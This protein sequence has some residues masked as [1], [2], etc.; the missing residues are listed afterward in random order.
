MNLFSIKKV[1]DFKRVGEKGGKSGIA[2]SVER[3]SFVIFKIKGCVTFRNR[4]L[5]G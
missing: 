1:V 2:G 5:V 3:F 4:N